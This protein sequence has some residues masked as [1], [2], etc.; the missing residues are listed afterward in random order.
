MNTNFKIRPVLMVLALIVWALIAQLPAP[1]VMMAQTGLRQP[2]VASQT[3]FGAFSIKV[4]AGTVNNGGHAVSVTAG[5]VAVIL[6][7]TD[8]SSPG[9]AS[10]NYIIANSSGTVSAVTS[11]S[12]ALASGN[13][14]LAYVE[15]STVAVT[16]IVGANQANTPVVGGTLIVN[17]GISA[18][19][20][21][22]TQVY[23]LGVRIFIGTVTMSSGAVTVSGISPAYTDVTTYGCVAGFST[24]T[25]AGSSPV[26]FTAVSSSS[27]TL[28]SSGGG[29]STLRFICTGY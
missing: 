27:F 5:S 1:S 2:S 23:G 10:C 28:A 18:T 25:S 21:T 11:L 20:A 15:T 6:S 13:S 22:P 16:R 24:S 3:A 14:L 26:T 8:C 29:T 19:C 17:C 4:T 7:K 9:Y 12:A